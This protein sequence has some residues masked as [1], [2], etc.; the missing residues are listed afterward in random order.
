MTFKII[1]QSVDVS[2]VSQALPTE[3]ID[4]RDLLV[5]M[6][7]ESAFI[8]NSARKKLVNYIQQINDD[9]GDTIHQK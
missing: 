1:M 5:R 8:R 7:S 9:C 6:H 4:I 3:V 2:Q